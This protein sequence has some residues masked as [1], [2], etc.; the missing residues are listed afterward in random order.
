MAETKFKFADFEDPTR[1][2]Y[3][4]EPISEKDR[5]NGMV[6]H[7]K[8]APVKAIHPDS[9]E[10]LGFVQ[11]TGPQNRYLHAR[12]CAEKYSNS[13]LVCE[14]CNYWRVAKRG[15]GLCLCSCH[16]PRRTE[17]CQFLD[18]DLERAGGK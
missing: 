18:N 9:G 13:K 8:V 16:P 5:E 15:A 14:K 11:P 2:S 6:L 1:C 7:V 10:V 3:C 17:M 12:P 4:R